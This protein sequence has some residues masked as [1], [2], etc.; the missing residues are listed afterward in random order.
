MSDL[1]KEKNEGSLRAPVE[2]WQAL[3]V[4]RNMVF[5]KCEDE[6]RQHIGFAPIGSF[7]HSFDVVDNHLH[8]VSL[9]GWLDNGE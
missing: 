8:R 9:D 5:R 1:E 3:S 2:F 6:Y 4:V 7:R